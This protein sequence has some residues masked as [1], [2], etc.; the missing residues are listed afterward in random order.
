MNQ[1]RLMKV[2]RGPHESE[3]S[4]IIA[5]KYRQIVFKVKRDATKKEIKQ[6]VEQLFEVKIDTVRT[7][8][9]KGKTK[10]FRQISGRRKD[11]KKAYVTLKEGFDISFTGGE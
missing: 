2:L 11:W 4:V 5:D 1:E 7:A 10:R 6:A 3:K 8:N 9:I